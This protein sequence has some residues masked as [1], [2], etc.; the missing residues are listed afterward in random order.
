[1]PLKIC[2]Q[3]GNAQNGTFGGLV[4]VIPQEGEFQIDGLTAGH[5]LQN[6][7]CSDNTEAC[8]SCSADEDCSGE[9]QTAPV[10]EAWAYTESRVLGR[11]LNTHTLSTDEDI[12]GFGQSALDW[13]L[14]QI[15]PLSDWLPNLL[16][17]TTTRRQ[18]KELVLPS[19]IDSEG[20]PI[21]VKMICGS[22][23]P[24]SGCLMP[25]PV[26]VMLESSDEFVDVYLLSLKKGQ[27]ND[28]DCG[29]WV[30]NRRREV[31]GH[32]VADDIFGDVYVVPMTD[33]FQDI[34]RSLG[35]RSVEMPSNIDLLS[36]RY[37]RLLGG[38]I[39]IYDVGEA[40]QKYE[41]TTTNE[42]VEIPP[43]DS[44][45]CSNQLS[46]AGANW[47]RSRSSAV[48]VHKPPPDSILLDSIL[49]S[50]NEHTTF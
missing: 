33:I 42:L 26:Q 27:I 24:S 5:I 41:Q 49:G 28:G 1:M 31:Y 12:V 3:T 20:E 23:G 43:A 47:H 36:S 46:P 6:L 7:S 8:C 13:M 32:A 25:L 48:H 37:Q 30:I 18:K 45:Y 29:S 19:G 39:G 35:A 9:C 11:V 44:G 17:S 21:H 16:P 14:F 15:N 38:N 22:K 4:K 2:D 50:C 34:E 40:Q 10:H